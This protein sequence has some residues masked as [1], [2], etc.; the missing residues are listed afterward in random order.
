MPLGRVPKRVSG[1]AGR[2]L[3]AC[4]QAGAAEEAGAAAAGR[5]CEVAARGVSARQVASASKGRREVMRQLLEIV[6]P[7]AC[8]SRE[9]GAGQAP[10]LKQASPIKLFRHMT[11]NKTIME[12]AQESF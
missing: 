3:A 5:R 12:W 2:S 10:R 9:S 4:G 7:A 11:V 8:Q 1:S 6:E